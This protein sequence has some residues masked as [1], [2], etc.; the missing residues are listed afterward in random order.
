MFNKS[1]YHTIK[2]IKLLSEL[3]M[4]HVCYFCTTEFMGM[5]FGFVRI[6]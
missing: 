5:G 2:S 3:T 6:H 1:K 4:H